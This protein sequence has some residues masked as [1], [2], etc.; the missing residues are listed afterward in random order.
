ML[1]F[2]HHAYCTYKFTNN[3]YDDHAH[4]V[5]LQLA[6]PELIIKVACHIPKFQILDE[7][8]GCD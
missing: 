5:L 7:I 1:I 3:T 2:V 8:L 4:F 6:T